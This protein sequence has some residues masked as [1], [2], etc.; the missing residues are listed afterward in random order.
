MDMQ[1]IGKFIISV[2]LIMVAIYGIKKLTQ[3]YNI[4]VIGTIAE[5]V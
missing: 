4:P 3:K 1:D 5:E 2:L